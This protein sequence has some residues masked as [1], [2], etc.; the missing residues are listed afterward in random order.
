VVIRPQ[1]KKSVV[2]KVQKSFEKKKTNKSINFK[3]S[4][5]CYNCG[6]PDHWANTCLKPKKST[7]T[8]KVSSFKNKPTSGRIK[9]KEEVAKADPTAN[10]ME[11]ELKNS[12][13]FFEAIM[14]N[15]EP[16]SSKNLVDY[17]WYFNSGATKHVSKN[18]FSFKGLENFTKVQNV[19]STRG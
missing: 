14:F 5:N 11:D 6:K 1:L 8:N 13:D 19:K 9:G 2:A 17:C 15:L 10:M 18:K 3:C 16:K 7:K 12:V 4:G